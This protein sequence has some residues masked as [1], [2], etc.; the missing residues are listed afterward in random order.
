VVLP[1]QYKAFLFQKQKFWTEVDKLL[2]NT[3]HKE[4]FK[5]L[6]D[7]MLAQTPAERLTIEGV[8]QHPWYTSVVPLTLEE[9][10]DSFRLRKQAIS[11]RKVVSPASRRR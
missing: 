10:K 1:E 9:V 11:A 3:G 7:K 8:Q 6:I 4:H 5:D 2:P